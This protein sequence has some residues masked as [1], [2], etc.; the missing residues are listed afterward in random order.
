MVLFELKML[1]EIGRVNPAPNEWLTILQR[2]FG[3]VVC[4]VPFHQVIGASHSETWTR[5][6]FDRIIVAQAKAAGGKLVSKDRRIRDHF[7]DTVW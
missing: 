5:D 3:V 1:Q 4:P 7:P 2:D 6:P